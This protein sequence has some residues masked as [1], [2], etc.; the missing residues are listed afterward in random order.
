[1]RA[2]LEQLLDDVTLKTLAFA[3][4]LGWSLFQVASGLS[5][6]I[7]TLLQ[8]FSSNP[9]DIGGFSYGGSLSWQVGHRVLAI[10]PLIGG[11]VE[12]TAVL[13]VALLVHTRFGCRR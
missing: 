12:F 2:D 10:G 1:V 13:L 4:A 11:L 6:F 8:R 5:Y 9:D 7:T 3:I